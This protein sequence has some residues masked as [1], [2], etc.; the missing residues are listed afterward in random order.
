MIPA[1]NPLCVRRMLMCSISPYGAKR[2]F[3]ISS[4]T[5]RGTWSNK[6]AQLGQTLMLFL[7]HQDSW[8]ML[9]VHLWYQE[10]KDFGGDTSPV[11]QT[12]SW[13][14]DQVLQVSLEVVFWGL[15]NGLPTAGLGHLLM[16]LPHLVLQ[17]LL[18]PGPS[19]CTELQPASLT[20]SLSIFLQSDKLGNILGTLESKM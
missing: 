20:P 17:Q 15:Q 6:D 16:L 1:L 13:E 2:G 9:P 10:S 7:K 11:Q 8:R 12:T 5:S 3:N 19:A 14:R 4:V 18:L